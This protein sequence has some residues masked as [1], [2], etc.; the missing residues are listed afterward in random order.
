MEN[1]ILTQIPLS[2]LETIIQKCVDNAINAN[3]LNPNQ[4]QVN[5]ELITIKQAAEF[6]S[7]SVPTIYSKVSKG[8]LPFMKVSKRL[9]FSREDLTSYIKS[10]RQNTKQEDKENAHNLLG[11]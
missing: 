8:E 5:S 1:I 3:S 6:L 9:Y 2:D 7:L 4:N 10:G 11:N